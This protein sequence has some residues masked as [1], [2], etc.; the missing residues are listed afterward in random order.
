MKE[1]TIHQGKNIRRFREMLGVKQDALAISL[2]DDWNQSKVSYLEQKDVIDPTILEEVAK[3]L[4]VSPEAIKNFDDD[5]VF[6]FINN[7]N[8]NIMIIASIMAR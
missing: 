7:F 6:S 4:N 1:K 8:D 5:A 3:A 2:G